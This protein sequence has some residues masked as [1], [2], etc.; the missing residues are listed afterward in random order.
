MPDLDMFVIR[1]GQTSYNREGRLQG[2]RD[3]GLN[4]LGL[5]QAAFNGKSLAAV[6]GFDAGRYDWVSGTRP[7]ASGGSTSAPGWP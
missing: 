1:H 7:S 3:I 2:Q 4:E 5:E 6:P